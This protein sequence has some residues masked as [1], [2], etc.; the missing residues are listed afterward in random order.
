[1]SFLPDD[2]EL[3]LKKLD[4]VLVDFNS[5]AREAVLME[6][7]RTAVELRDCLER[8]RQDGGC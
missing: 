5:T 6:R 1:M 2:I 3:E 7:N 4:K 8:L